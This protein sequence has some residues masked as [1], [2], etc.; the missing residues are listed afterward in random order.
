MSLD[1]NGS[2]KIW[3]LDSLSGARLSYSIDDQ[4]CKIVA[5]DLWGGTIKTEN[6]DNCWMTVLVFLTEKLELNAYYN[7][8]VTES[9]LVDD[10]SGSSNSMWR[11]MCKMNICELLGVDCLKD[12]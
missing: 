7:H 4:M 8:N 12:L 10:N 6:G 5:A 11:L 2:L 9:N 1:V 3:N